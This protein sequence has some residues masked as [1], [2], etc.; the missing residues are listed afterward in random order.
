MRLH[1][2]PNGH[3]AARYPAGVYVWRGQVQAA[4]AALE[5][6]PFV[7]PVELR[8]GFDLPRPAGHFGTG[9]NA[10][11]LKPS[12]PAHPAVMP[13]LDK[14]VRCVCDAITDAALWKD[15]SQVVVLHAAK[16]FASAPPGGVLITIT[17]LR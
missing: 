14:L 15:D 8:L 5:V 1:Q 7:G 9:R 12:A 16:R 4:V 3:T 6:E 2:L 11:V 10:G 13:D 17:E